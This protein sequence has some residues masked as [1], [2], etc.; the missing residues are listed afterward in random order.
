MLERKKRKCNRFC[1][2]R[3]VYCPCKLKEGRWTL[4]QGR[5]WGDEF[6]TTTVCVDAYGGKVLRG[7][8]YNSYWG[9]TEF[10]SVMEFLLKMEELLDNMNFPQSFMAN[11]SFSQPTE[12][13]AHAPPGGEAQTGKR[14]TFAV[15]VIFRQ[16]ASWQGS[17]YWLEGRREESFRSVLELLM[18]MNSALEAEGG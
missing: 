10:G 18:L 14:A 1:N 15:R 12:R 16:N 13:A 17:V 6:R 9:V 3:V 4:V 5:A 7:R 8:L 2:R 11:R